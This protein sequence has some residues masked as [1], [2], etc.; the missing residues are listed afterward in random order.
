MSVG[1][2]APD[3]SRRRDKKERRWR[4]MGG[5]QEARRQK[6]GYDVRTGSGHSDNNVI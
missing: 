6:A 1:P 5:G 3:K 4:E 2:S